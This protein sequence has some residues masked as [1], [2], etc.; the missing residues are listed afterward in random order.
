M[1]RRQF[2][3]MVLAYGAQKLWGGSGGIDEALRGGLANRK[4]PAVTAIVA[5]PDKILYTGAFGKRDAASGVAV[6]PDSMFRIASMTKAITTTAIMQLVEQGK[7]TID[8][9]VSKYL[10]ALGALQILD[11]FDSSGAPKLRPQTKPIALKHLLTHT[12]GCV[13][14]N[15]DAVLNQYAQKNSPSGDALLNP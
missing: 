9:P 2:G 14:S 1:N 3:G 13:Y 5:T 6:T 12:S 8:E 4:I 11:G 7:V 15:W 10:P